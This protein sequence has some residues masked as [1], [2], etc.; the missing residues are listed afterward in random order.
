MEIVDIDI[1][2]V[3][4]AAVILIL[5]LTTDDWLNT[6]ADLF[7]IRFG[8]KYQFLIFIVKISNPLFWV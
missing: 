3:E 4:N 6:L 5:L 7:Y 2:L 8:H 1:L